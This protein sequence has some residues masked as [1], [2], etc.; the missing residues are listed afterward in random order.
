MAYNKRDYAVSKSREKFKDLA[1]V[2]QLYLSKQI[3]KYSFQ[4]LNSISR[5]ETLSKKQ[6]DILLRISKHV[7]SLENIKP[8]DKI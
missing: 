5:Y 3:D 6:E 1:Y 7:Y 4:F 2:K 8:F